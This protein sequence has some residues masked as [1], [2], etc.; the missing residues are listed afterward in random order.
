[1]TL[2]TLLPLGLA[3]ACGTPGAL[4]AEG[5]ERWPDGNCY[6]GGLGGGTVPEPPTPPTPPDPTDTGLDGFY[7]GPIYVEYANSRCTLTESG[8]ILTTRTRGWAL[9][10]TVAVFG[11]GTATPDDEEH[12][13]FP[14]AQH[15]GGLWDELEVGPLTDETPPAQAVRNLNT[16][17]DCA[18]EDLDLLTFVVRI[19]DLDQ[20]LLDCVVWGHDEARVMSGGATYA[21]VSPPVDFSACFDL[22]GPDT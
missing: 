5:F 21:N 4:C 13:L 20:Q 19:Y 7:D 10:A 6:P 14:V 17:F 3:V 15:A 9:R 22:D 11:T 16:R 2:R 8:L 18:D 1:M 12:D